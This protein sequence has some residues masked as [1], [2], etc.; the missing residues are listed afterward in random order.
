MHRILLYLLGLLFTFSSFSIPLSKQDT[1]HVVVPTLLPTA[2]PLPTPTLTPT[3]LPT[4]TPE[5]TVAPESVLGYDSELTLLYD[6]RC[7]L[8]VISLEKSED[9]G[10]LLKLA[11]ENLCDADIDFEMYNFY[12]NGL[13]CDCVRYITL[14]ANSV[15]ETDLLLVFE[16]FMPSPLP[17]LTG[18]V[19]EVSADHAEEGYLALQKHTLE[20]Y[21]QGEDTATPYEHPLGPQDVVIADNPYYTLTITGYEYTD[22]EYLI[23]FFLKNN[24]SQRI[25]LHL[26]QAL[27]QGVE[28][29]PYWTYSIASGMRGYGAIAFDRFDLEENNITDITE[30]TL[31]ITA[32]AN[33]EKIFCEDR[34]ILTPY[35]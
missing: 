34:F 29:S 28:Y 12:V 14:P 17:E 4:V 21:P 26:D 20:Y 13:I 9:S 1:N 8:Q 35:H 27:F 32:M 6:N 2:T 5:P 23:H 25:K 16:C 15:T 31:D 11:I 3:P 10:Y 33:Y 22:T 19:F 24:C 30:L 18:L 7:I